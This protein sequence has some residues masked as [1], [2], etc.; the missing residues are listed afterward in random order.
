VRT[1]PLDYSRADARCEERSNQL[2]SSGDK[3]FNEF[4]EAFTADDL[5]LATMMPDQP[6]S[7]K[8]AEGFRDGLRGAAEKLSEVVVAQS[9][10][11]GVAQLS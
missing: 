7:R 5:D 9:E 6:A 2:H 10:G 8:L 11:R 4:S 1:I 3:T